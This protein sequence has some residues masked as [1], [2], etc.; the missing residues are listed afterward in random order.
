MKPVTSRH[1][2]GRGGRAPSESWEEEIE[3]RGGP[4]GPR[5]SVCARGCA[6]RCGAGLPAPSSPAEAGAGRSRRGAPWGPAQLRAAILPP[7]VAAGAEGLPGT[8]TGP[9][10]PPPPARLPLARPTSERAARP[11]QAAA[12]SPTPPRPQPQ[13]S[14][15]AV[16]S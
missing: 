13:R 2:R 10:P 16:P 15:A 1:G 14:P 9:A 6:Q 11:A 4:P 5:V 12:P 3:Q 7:P 8:G